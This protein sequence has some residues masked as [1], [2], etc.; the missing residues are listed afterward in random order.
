[1]VNHTTNAQDKIAGNVFDLQTEINKLTAVHGELQQ[2]REH[3]VH[4]HD[5][6]DRLATSKEPY[7]IEIIHAIQEDL[8]ELIDGN[9]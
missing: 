4:I 1:M 3:I 9:R 2:V 5:A 7:N 8:K 6:V